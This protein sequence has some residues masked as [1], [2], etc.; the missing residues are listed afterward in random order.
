MLV[1]T[2]CVQIGLVYT[3]LC[4]AYNCA[5]LHMQVDIAVILLILHE[6]ISVVAFGRILLEGENK[7]E[8]RRKEKNQN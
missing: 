8:R 7:V 6:P 4:E 3:Y 2:A 1:L 5:I